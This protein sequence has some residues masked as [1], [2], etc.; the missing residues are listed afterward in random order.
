MRRVR[1]IIVLA[2]LLSSCIDLT[3]ARGVP[4]VEG[5]VTRIV[6]TTVSGSGP[7]Q[8]VEVELLTPPNTGVREL[9][10]WGGAGQPISTGSLL[11]EGDHVILTRLPSQPASDPHRIV[12]IVRTPALAV[13]GSLLALIVFAVARTKGLASLAGLALSAVVFFAVVIP[14]IVRGDDPIWWTLLA[15]VVVLILSVYV[16]HGWNRKSSVALAGAVGGLAMVALTALAM[17]SLARIG[18]TSGAGADI[19]QLPVL[20]GRVDVAHLAL[21]AMILG[22]LGALVDMTVGQSSAT[23][24][25]AAVDPSLRG[26]HLYRRALNVGT[27][28]IGALVNTVGFAYFA[29]ALPLLVLLAGRGDALSI[30]LNDE[31]IVGALIAT[32]VACIGLVAA[33]PLTSGIA[34][35]LLGPAPA[36]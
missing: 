11:R 4:A 2:L 26:W 14:A 8:Q 13:A 19:A 29:G 21:A 30:A 25:L 17:T 20:R 16:V 28:H 27:D 23:F 15:S 12:G 5:V 22:G 6:S 31:G 18:G 35:W 24:E 9:L 34:V 33:V 32:A 36:R 10:Y 3:S 7:L 1:P